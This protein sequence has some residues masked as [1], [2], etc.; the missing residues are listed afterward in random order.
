MKAWIITIFLLLTASAVLAAGYQG[1][2]QSGVTVSEFMPRYFTTYSTHKAAVTVNTATLGT[3]Q[4]KTSAICTVKINGAGDGWPT[5]ANT[6]EEARI[7]VGVNSYVFNCGSTAMTAK[8][9]IYYKA[10]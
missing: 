2:D 10:Q 9:K 8:T 4:Y 5:V 7:P 6:A 3:I 1:K